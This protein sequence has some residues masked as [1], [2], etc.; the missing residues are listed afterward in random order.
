MPDWGH[1]TPEVR[2]A[3]PKPGAPLAALLRRLQRHRAHVQLAP[4][5]RKFI[6][7]SFQL[8]GSMCSARPRLNLARSRR[9]LCH[10]S[11]SQDVF[12]MVLNTS[13]H[14]G[15]LRLRTED[16]VPIGLSYLITPLL[17]YGK[18]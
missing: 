10:A 15:L 8:Q 14:L 16:A 4:D 3:T 1:K 9:W 6:K 2:L 18:A 5:S 13:P 7:R 17:K 12:G 11:P